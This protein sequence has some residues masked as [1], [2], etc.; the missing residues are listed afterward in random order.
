MKY[1][2]PQVEIVEFETETF[3][4]EKKAKAAKKIKTIPFLNAD[5]IQPPICIKT[6]KYNKSLKF[7]RKFL[8]KQI[9]FYVIVIV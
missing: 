2:K 4:Q 6:F 1:Q 5:F 3:E 8:K 9:I 7:K